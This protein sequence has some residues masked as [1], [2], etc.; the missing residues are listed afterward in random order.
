[1]DQNDGQEKLSEGTEP[2]LMISAEDV[3][4]EFAVDDEAPPLESEDEGDDEDDDNDGDAIE[5]PPGIRLVAEYED[6][7]MEELGKGGW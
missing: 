1:M 3:L 7:H 5:L 4:E 2:P 6:G